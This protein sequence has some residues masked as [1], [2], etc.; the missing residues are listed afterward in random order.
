MRSAIAVVLCGLVVVAE[1][2]P[3]GA[4]ATCNPVGPCGDVDGSG[5]VAASDALRVLRESVGLDGNVLCLCEADGAAVTQP[6]KTGQTECYNAAGTAVSCV[7]T[8]QDGEL[9]LGAARSFTDNG[10]GTITDETTG[11]QWEKLSDDGSVHDW[12]SQYT[13]EDAFGKT[14]AL[15]AASFA[16]HS[17]WRLP[18]RF[19]LETLVN[20]AAPIPLESDP[21]TY[22]IFH[23]GCALGCPPTTCSC[24]RSNFYWSSTTLA[25]FPA[26]AW[27]MSFIDGATDSDLKTP[28]THFARAVRSGA[29]D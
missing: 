19:E 4:Q 26:M 29:T 24:T 2:V 6:L 10:D 20:L 11:L 5:G 25:R 12:N 22:S 14:D 8:A 18:N 7:G 21:A 17:D 27:C 28:S 1:V 13:W 23:G 15:N 16:G 3:A 9:Q